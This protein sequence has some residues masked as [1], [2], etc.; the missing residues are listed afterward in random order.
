MTDS[1][2]IQNIAATCNLADNMYI[3][4]LNFN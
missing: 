2:Y 4:S 3:L 1:Y